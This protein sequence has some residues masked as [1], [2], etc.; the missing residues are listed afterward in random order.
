MRAGTPAWRARGP[1]MLAGKSVSQA[2]RVLVV[3]LLLG[4][5]AG[6]DSARGPQE[7]ARA[8]RAL[9]L[10]DAGSLP[11]G[12]NDSGSAWQ[13]L[14]RGVTVYRETRADSSGVQTR[15][16]VARLDLEHVAL[17]AL[18]VNEHRLESLAA[19]PEVLLAVNGG[20]FEP[21]LEA[22]GLLVS[23]QRLLH[24]WQERGG[25]G[26]LS[27]RAGRASVSSEPPRALSQLELA[28]QC[29]P[30]LI[31]ADGTLGIA[32]DD[33]KRAERTA[34]CMRR[35]GREL[36][37][38]LAYATDRAR[39]GPSL[40]QL[41]QWLAAPLTPLDETGCES[42]LNLDGGPST[43]LVAPA[44]MATDWRLP[45]GPVPWAL[46]VLARSDGQPR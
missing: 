45:R 4:C 19:R 33:R 37:L 21:N 40:L 7:P 34:V 18:P 24:G 35:Q 16:L 6:S 14:A 8:Q 11:T 15:W 44:L 27:V 26:V 32:R 9:V 10:P 25:S 3:L 31:E 20:F 42:A 1:G 2:S 28:M 38:V 46:A 29:G 13:A 23:E 41:A 30:R 43:G 22:S 5:R 12:P 36:D 17:R 39:D